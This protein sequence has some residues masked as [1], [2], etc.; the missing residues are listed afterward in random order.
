M[1]STVLAGCLE[2]RASPTLRRA[3]TWWVPLVVAGASVLLPHG[4]P[5]TVFAIAAGLLATAVLPRGQALVAVATAAAATLAEP[6]LVLARDGGDGT[7]IDATT[8]V[9][10]LVFVLGGCLLVGSLVGALRRTRDAGEQTS[11]ELDLHVYSGEFGDDGEYVERFTGPGLE[12]FLGRPLRPGERSGDAWE[13]AVH[14]DDRGAYVAFFSPDGLFGRDAAELEYRLVGADSRARWVLDRVH[15]GTPEGGGLRVSGFCIDITE[16]RVEAD[17]LRDARERVSRLVDVVD[18]VFFELELTVGGDL[19][20]RHVNAGIER[21][22]G[23]PAGPDVLAA[24]RD[25]VHEDDRSAWRDHVAGMRAG[26]ACETEYRL[27]GA[28]GVERTVWVRVF[29]HH[30]P[31]GSLLLIGVLSDISERT[32]L[33]YDLEVALARAERQAKTDALTGLANRAH[34]GE[35]LDGRLS[36][37]DTAVCTGVLLLD[38]D[39]FKRINDTH[40]HQAGDEVLI[41]LAHRLTRVVGERGLVAR[42]GGEEL[43]VL[44]S[45]VRH[46]VGLREIAEEVRAAIADMPMVVEGG[47]RIPVSVSIGA[48]QGGE[49]FPTR[50]SLLSAADRALY[51]AKRRG[52]N[53]V[54]LVGDLTSAD[55]EDQVPEAVKIAQSLALLAGAREGVAPEHASEVARIAEEVATELGLPPDAIRRCVL[56]GWLHDIGKASIPDRILLKR[57]PLDDE[58]WEAMRHHVELGEDIVRQVDEIAVAAPAVRHHHEHVDGTGYPDGLAGE[59]IPVD[60]RVVAAADAFVAIVADRVHARGLAP[61]EAIDELRRSVGTHL[62]PEIVEALARVITR[63]AR[64]LDRRQHVRHPRAA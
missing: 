22:L 40:G 42:L 34:L 12:H 19:V 37:P 63:D 5:V 26:E 44:V 7:W 33:A 52:R 47:V 45:G 30:D 41:E 23:R 43:A 39:R 17:E 16:R 36:R 58:E 3:V 28:D 27:V 48:A 64:Q 55:L 14:P 21:L 15:M 29:P 61:D 56:G 62:D 49:N 9:A 18:D 13:S 54:L 20:A 46:E 38:V 24:W 31:G 35:F 11:R 60:A 1:L 59:A 53:R 51:A 50:D 57:G 10:R 2:R 6:L 25:A 4:A 8:V 32:Q